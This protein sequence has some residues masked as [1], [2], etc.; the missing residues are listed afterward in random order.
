[1]N[2]FEKLKRLKVERDLWWKM[3][4][5]T[6]VKENFDKYLTGTLSPEVE[7][8]KNA[9]LGSAN[10][11]NETLYNAETKLEQLDKELS[12]RLLFEQY[13]YQKGDKI[14]Q[15]CTTV[16]YYIKYEE[17]VVY[18]RNDGCTP[19]FQI[20]GLRYRKDGSEGKRY[21]NAFLPVKD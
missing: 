5:F 19:E 17:C 13:G 16:T 7:K 11:I 21:D 15:E 10:K 2:T 8:A 9:L 12:A 1:M 18:L 3:C 14:R 6:S 4:Q 20:T